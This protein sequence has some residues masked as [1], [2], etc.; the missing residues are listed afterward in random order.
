MI[1]EEYEIR[2]G[3]L[4]DHQKYPVPSKDMEKLKQVMLH[5]LNVFH[6]YAKEHKIYYSLS[7]GSLIGFYCGGDMIP[8]DDDIDIE[9][10]REGVLHVIELYQSGKM[11]NTITK[12]KSGFDTT[13]T[14]IIELYGEKFE[15]IMDKPTYTPETVWLMKLRPVDHCCFLNCP[16][17]LDI[18]TVYVNTAGKLVNSWDMCTL[19]VNP[20]DMTST[21]CPEVSFGGV[22]TRALRSELGERY[23]NRLYGDKWSIKQHPSIKLPTP[24]LFSRLVNKLRSML[25]PGKRMMPVF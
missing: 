16:G 23:L 21:G 20:K 14:R 5:T 8:W 4:S 22:T 18:S 25:R 1:I 9:I 24:S 3:T 2:A 11:P 17:G 7:G 13:H 10:S 12:Y 6:R 19:G 15:I